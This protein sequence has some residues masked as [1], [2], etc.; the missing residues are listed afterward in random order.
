MGETTQTPHFGCPAPF[1]VSSPATPASS[2]GVAA[3]K[4][5]LHRR[6]YPPS[7]EQSGASPSPS[8]A[9]AGEGRGAGMG[10]PA[11]TAPRFSRQGAERGGPG[12]G[13]DVRGRAGAAAPD[14]PSPLRRREGERRAAAGSQPARRRRMAPGS[15]TSPLHP[16]PGPPI[17][18]ASS[19]SA[20]GGP[21][22]CTPF[23]VH[24]QYAPCELSVHPFSR[25]IPGIAPTAPS[26]HPLSR[27]SPPRSPC[28]LRA[29]PQCI[30]P[31]RS[32]RPS[33]LRAPCTPVHSRP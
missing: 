14:P 30:L 22:P 1:R 4:D 28:T 25:A 21:P 17:T 18:P 9:P 8:A 24:P 15:R 13:R 6:I 5:I 26:V 19:P 11:A 7:P 31:A 12:P 20:P 29:P 23:P 27:T 16:S 10:C 3:P 33:L 2:W 32:P